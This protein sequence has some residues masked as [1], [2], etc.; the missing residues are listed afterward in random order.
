MTTMTKIETSKLLAICT[1]L[2]LTVVEQPSQYRV[3]GTDPNLRMYIPGTKR[4]HKVE[5]SGWKHDLAVTWESVF[6][7]K[8]APSGKITHVVDFA[9]DE[10]SILKD[11]IRIARAIAPKPASSPAPEAP[12]E[13]PASEPVVE[14]AS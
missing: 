9:Q 12:A 7:G 4:V 6:P 8:K 5:L 2:G 11:F 13:A 1:K 3:Q 14:A 10:K